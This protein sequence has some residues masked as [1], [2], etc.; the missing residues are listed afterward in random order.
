[1]L[2]VVDR[3]YSSNYSNYLNAFIDLRRQC[4][5]YS[6]CSGRHCNF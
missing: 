4:L 6:G 3:R 1:V 5:H 2:E